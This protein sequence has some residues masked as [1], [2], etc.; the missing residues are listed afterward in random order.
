MSNSSG[1]LGSATATAADVIHFNVTLDIREDDG[2]GNFS[3]CPKD[4][5]VYK[6]RRDVEKRMLITVTQLSDNRPLPI[7]RCVVH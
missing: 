4:K 3:S 2:R 7:E 6:L 5:N 1:D